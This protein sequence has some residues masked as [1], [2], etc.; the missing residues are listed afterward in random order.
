M[1]HN[2]QK[3][4]S[5]ITFMAEQNCF[6]LIIYKG[7]YKETLLSCSGKVMEMTAATCQRFITC[8]SKVSLSPRAL[9]RILLR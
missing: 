2:F 8:C 4:K 9:P 3:L 7:V 5:G 1:F 6:R